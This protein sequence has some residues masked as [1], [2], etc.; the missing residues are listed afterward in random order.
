MMR[1]AGIVGP[2]LAVF[3]LVRSP[4]HGTSA[5][6]VP[7]TIAEL[8]PFTYSSQVEHN[9]EICP[10]QEGVLFQGGKNASEETTKE[11]PD[12][13]GHRSSHVNSFSHSHQQLF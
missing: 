10:F 1:S 5:L 12:K 13:I 9:W 2:W 8:W 11:V 6:L 7:T 4:V 3:P